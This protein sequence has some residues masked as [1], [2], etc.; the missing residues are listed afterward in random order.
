MPE[1]S[2]EKQDKHHQHQG[3]ADKSEAF[4]NPKLTSYPSYLLQISEYYNQ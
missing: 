4:T 1:W 2:K 3:T